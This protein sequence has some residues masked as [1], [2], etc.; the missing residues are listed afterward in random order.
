LNAAWL[1][2]IEKRKE[3]I[4]NSKYYHLLRGQADPELYRKFEL[5]LMRLVQIAKE[6]GAR[7]LVVL[8]PDVVQLNNPELQGINQTLEEIS[9]QCEVDFLDITPSFERVLDIKRLYLF[10]HD[11][12]TSP[13]GHQIIAEGIEKKIKEMMIEYS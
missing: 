11:A 9:R 10:P 5:R 13:E 12:H 4:L 3:Y 1:R 6:H 8:I 2:S 7:V